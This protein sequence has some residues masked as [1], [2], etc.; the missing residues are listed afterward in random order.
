MSRGNGKG[1]F[2]VLMFDRVVEETIEHTISDP[3]DHCEWD[4]DEYLTIYGTEKGGKLFYLIIS[5]KLVDLIKNA[6]T[7]DEFFQS[8]SRS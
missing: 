4:N 5:R 7:A 3:A 6:P 8:Q 2:S 1:W